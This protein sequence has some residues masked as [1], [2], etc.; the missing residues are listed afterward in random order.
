M[1]LIPDLQGKQEGLAIVRFS[2]PS[3]NCIK[4]L[5]PI[6]LIWRILSLC[7]YLLYAL[8]VLVPKASPLEKV[9]CLLVQNPPAMPLLAIVCFYSFVKGLWTGLRPRVVIDWHNLGFS[10][11]SNPIFSRVARVYEKIIAPY[12][13]SMYR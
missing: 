10:M 9:D 5:L 11:L 1:D 13:D 3:P 7:L 6:Y 8:F 4:K 12:A 2:V